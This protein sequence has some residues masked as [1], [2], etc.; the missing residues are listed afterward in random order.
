[1]Q[2]VVRQ[3]SLHQIK[4]KFQCTKSIYFLGGGGE[5]PKL[6]IPC[7]NI[8]SV[9]HANSFSGAPVTAR[10]LHRKSRGKFQNLAVSYVLKHV[11]NTYLS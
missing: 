8:F 1:M 9:T 6:L 10:N 5:K 7:K 4:G 11:L 2:V 3:V